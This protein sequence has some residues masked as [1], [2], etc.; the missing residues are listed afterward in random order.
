MGKDLGTYHVRVE[1]SVGT[2]DGRGWIET[3]NTGHRYTGGTQAVTKLDAQLITPPFKDETELLDTI[4][5]AYLDGNYS[6][7]CN[8]RLSLDQAYQLPEQENYPCGDEIM[9]F[10]LTVIRPDASEI[11]LYQREKS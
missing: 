4:K 6:C 10:R 3:W 9:I 11:V 5:Y 1:L 8:K 7:D 2:P